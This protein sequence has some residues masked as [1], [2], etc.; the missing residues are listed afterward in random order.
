VFAGEE[1]LSKNGGANGRK[2]FLNRLPVLRM[3]KVTN[4]TFAQL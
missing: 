4:E 2:V 3:M 1:F